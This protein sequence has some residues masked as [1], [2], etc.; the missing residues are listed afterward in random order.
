VH[1]L[2]FFCSFWLLH[3]IKEH[4]LFKS[5]HLYFLSL[6]DKLREHRLLSV[7][8]GLSAREEVRIAWREDTESQKLALLGELDSGKDDLT[9]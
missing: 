1:V 5:V 7:M 3:E 2:T 9:A 4:P 8:D 6:N